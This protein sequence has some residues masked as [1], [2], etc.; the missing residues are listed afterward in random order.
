MK[1]MV[2][3]L[4]LVNLALLAWMRWGGMLTQE[5]DGPVAQAALNADKVVLLDL[6]SAPSGVAAAVSGVSLTLSPLVPVAPAPDAQKADHGT[7]AEWGEFSGADLARASAALDA[8]KLG[9]RLTQRIVEQDHGWWVYIPPLK[10]KAAVE[11][12]VEQLKAR[13][14]EDYFV[15]QA[16]GTW[17]NAISLGVFKTEEAAQRYLAVVQSRAVRSATIGER[18]TRLKFTVF[19][20]KD[21]QTVE[22]EKLAVMQKD[23]PD[24]KLASQACGN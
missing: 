22:M 4:L 13:G 3:L 5:S 10:S 17:L 8:M 9:E 21:L 15:V 18:S 19:V 11:R 23:F 14:V 20:L 6:A 1:R 2:G 24:S 12:K 7:C 16:E